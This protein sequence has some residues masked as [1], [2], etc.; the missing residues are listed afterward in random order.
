MVPQNLLQ[1][2]LLNI[3]HQQDGTAV[4]P[5]ELFSPHERSIQQLNFNLFQLLYRETSVIKIVHELSDSLLQ[6]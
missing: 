2:Q 3:N 4:L 6:V 1:S 5:T